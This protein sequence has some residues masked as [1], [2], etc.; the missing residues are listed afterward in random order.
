MDSEELA[1]A[2]AAGL[3]ADLGTVVAGILRDKGVGGILASLGGA[4]RVTV[5]ARLE[6]GMSVAEA[7]KTWNPG[8]L[9]GLRGVAPFGKQSREAVTPP[10]LVRVACECVHAPSGG[11]SSYYC[12]RGTFVSLLVSIPAR[13]IWDARMEEAT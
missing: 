7:H 12:F 3:P 5:E 9:D 1:V 6:E 11:M 8:A 2:V 4:P 13:A 10:G